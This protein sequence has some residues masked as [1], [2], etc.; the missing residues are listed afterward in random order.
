MREWAE[1][2]NS[3]HP[4][5][6]ADGDASSQMGVEIEQHERNTSTYVASLALS[7]PL[8]SS[9]CGFWEFM[10]DKIAQRPII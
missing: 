9:S 1:Y 2:K 4:L 7:L 3:C 8:A 6:L 10:M 5:I